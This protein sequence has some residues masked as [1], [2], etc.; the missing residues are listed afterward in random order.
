M[1][2]SYAIGY[3]TSL[4]TPGDPCIPPPSIS[5][6]GGGIYTKNNHSLY[7]FFHPLLYSSA[8]PY[9]L[10][11][12]DSYMITNYSQKGCF[13]NSMMKSIPSLQ[14]GAISAMRAK[15]V[16]L[17]NEKQAELCYCFMLLL[18]P[19]LFPCYAIALSF[20]LSLILFPI[21]FPFP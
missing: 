12:H 7:H 15:S 3:E 8:L 1:G 9:Y 4:G 14:C 19:S 20:S 10:L 16:P 17:K 11:L 13:T 6:G 18:Y 21:P 2:Y 5:W